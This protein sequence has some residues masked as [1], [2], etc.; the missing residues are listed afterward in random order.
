MNQQTAGTAGQPTVGF[1][2][3]RARRPLKSIYRKKGKADMSTT[4][5]N[6]G[7]TDEQK[8]ENA[9]RQKLAAERTAAALKEK[10]DEFNRAHINTMLT[11]KGH[12]GK[13]PSE[14]HLDPHTKLNEKGFDSVDVATRAVK[15]DGK[16]TGE[17]VTKPEAVREVTAH[18]GAPLDRAQ[19]TAAVA[20]GEDPDANS[21][22]SRASK[23][24]K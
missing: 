14:P 1:P 9:R 18:A 15:T 8:K 13:H 10:E 7:P 12:I 23:K 6:H 3:R 22:R 20:R 19:K 21:K 17:V 4:I 24:K 5:I 11:D 2:I 16:T